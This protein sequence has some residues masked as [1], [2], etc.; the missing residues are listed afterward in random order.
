MADLTRDPRYVALVKALEED[1]NDEWTSNALNDLIQE[2]GADVRLADVT[3]ACVRARFISLF[4]DTV[5]LKLSGKADGFV[6]RYGDMYTRPVLPLKTLL[7]LVDLFGTENIRTDA[8]DKAGCETCDNG[9][10]YGHEIY[11]VGATKNTDHIP[12]DL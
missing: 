2:E 5:T 9:S 1:P 8:Y 10:D 7:A 3:K 6:I 11:V 4:K 12:F